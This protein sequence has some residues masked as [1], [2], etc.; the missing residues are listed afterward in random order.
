MKAMFNGKLCDLV[1]PKNS[2]EKITLKAHAFRTA[3]S[4]VEI[5]VQP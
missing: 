1:Y 4:K 2:N 3:I 5:P